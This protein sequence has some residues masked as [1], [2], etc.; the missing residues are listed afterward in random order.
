[1]FFR[2]KGTFFSVSFYLEILF[3]VTLSSRDGEAGCD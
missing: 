2:H 3:F 1:M